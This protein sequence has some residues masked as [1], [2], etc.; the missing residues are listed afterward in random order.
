MDF[1]RPRFR[2][3]TTGPDL[4]LIRALYGG[5]A[6]NAT[7]NPGWLF[8]INMTN[9]VSSF[10]GPTGFSITGLTETM[11]SMPVPEPGSPAL[12]GLGLAALGYRKRSRA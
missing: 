12:L 3:E 11:A 5:T 6:Q 2:I 1:E 7:V 8:S 4:H 10:I 9:G